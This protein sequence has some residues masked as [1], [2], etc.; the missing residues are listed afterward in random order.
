MLLDLQGIHVT[1]LAEQVE[2]K[3]EQGTKVPFSHITVRELAVDL[4]VALSAVFEY[5]DL[6]GWHAP[7]KV[8]FEVL[9]LQRKARCVPDAGHNTAGTPG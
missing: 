9:H 3:A 5:S 2:V 8:A 6:L 7:D 1:L 4:E